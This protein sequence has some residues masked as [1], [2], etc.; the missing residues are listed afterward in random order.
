MRVTR[1]DSPDVSEAVR[2]AT[3]VR[4]EVVV[5]LC[6]FCV[7]CPIARAATAGTASVT[8]AAGARAVGGFFRHECRMS[9][10]NALEHPRELE[11]CEGAHAL[12]I[13]VVHE[14]VDG[15]EA[16]TCGSAPATPVRRGL[17]I[18]ISN[19]IAGRA[20]TRECVG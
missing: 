12:V 8:I 3:W 15:I 7:A 10:L 2:E 9:Q 16:T 11:P 17:G 13:G 18:R 4:Q 5:F 19:S 6:K 20:P 14:I 1:G